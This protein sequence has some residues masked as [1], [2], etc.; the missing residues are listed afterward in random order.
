M[1]QLGQGVVNQVRSIGNQVSDGLAG[2]VGQATGTLAQG[3]FQ[4]IGAGL[5]NLGQGLLNPNARIAG[6]PEDSGGYSRY[7]GGSSGGYSSGLA[8]DAYTGGASL[9]P[10]AAYGGSMMMAGGG[11]SSGGTAGRKYTRVLLQSS[12]LP[13]RGLAAAAGSSSTM[14]SSSS[15]SAG[16]GSVTDSDGRGSGRSL[17]QV[18]FFA[19]PMALQDF[20]SQG[21][22]SGSFGTQLGQNTDLGS[23]L[24]A[25]MS[26][27]A[28]SG[29]GIGGNILGGNAAGA[30][31]AGGLGTLAR[32]AGLGGAADVFSSAAARTGG[33]TGL[34]SNVVGGGSGAAARKSSGG[35]GLSGLF[36]GLTHRFGR[37]SSNDNNAG[38][39]AAA[40]D[41]L[42]QL[43]GTGSSST[44]YNPFGQQAQQQQ[45]PAG[46]TLEQGSLGASS[47]S[48]GLA[49]AGQ[50]NPQQQN[51]YMG[52]DMYDQAFQQL[53]RVPG[54]AV[55]ALA[56]YGTGLANQGIQSAQ[57]LGNQ[58]FQQASQNLANGEPVLGGS[59]SQPL[60]VPGLGQDPNTYVIGGSDYYPG[61]SSNNQVQQFNQVPGT[62]N[63]ATGQ[64]VPTTSR[65]NMFS[66]G[67]LGTGGQ[68]VSQPTNP[69]GVID[70]A[71]GREEMRDECLVVG[72]WWWWC[73]DRK[74]EA[75]G[76]GAG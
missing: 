2:S 38:T 48:Q 41:G 10:E 68:F 36:S 15:S 50:Q 13:G 3:A 1:G 73:E 37:G 33:L 23:Q 54:Q 46:Y 30:N 40:L 43:G 6:K 24:Q 11:S 51:P 19:A 59:Q 12:H 20:V 29:A 32:L 69:S 47:G 34:L 14:G 66:G 60:V 5:G 4:G 65:N 57:N 45:Q 31:T 42:S 63:L 62:S 8:Q 22:T 58:V 75:S 39:A 9:Y 71:T 7:T 18:D 49:A 72:W 53:T 67:S 52:A 76:G 56:G 64:L 61:G 70:P 17:Q 35:G 16:A 27:L 55:G 21:V 74:E 44:M 26:A 28:G 25:G